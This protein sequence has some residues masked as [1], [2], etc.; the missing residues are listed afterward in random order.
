[1]NSKVGQHGIATILELTLV[2]AILIILTS[3]VMLYIRP[4]RQHKRSRDVVRVADMTTL[5]RAIEE[6][7][8]DKTSYPDNTNTIRTSDTLPLGNLGPNV[9]AS[10]GWIDSDF[11][12]YLTRLPID[13]LNTGSNVYKYIASGTNYEINAVLEY[14]SSGLMTKDGGNNSSVYEVGTSLTLIN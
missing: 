2:V 7:R 4:V 12:G 10:D 3:V 14:D 6:Y 5:S 8:L 13:P 11:K 1:M 9:N